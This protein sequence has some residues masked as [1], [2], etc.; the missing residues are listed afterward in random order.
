VPLGVVT[1]AFDPVLKFGDTASVRLETIGL[2][3]VLALGL[4]LAAR[5]ASVTPPDVTAGEVPNLRLDD[6][7]FIA[8]GTVPGAIAGGRLGYVLDHLDFY[9]ANP[10]L[11]VDATQGGMTLTWAVPLG[12][13]T[14]ALIARLVGAPVGRW[15]HAVTLPL[16]FVLGLG[17]LVGVLGGTGLGRYDT[18][19][20]ALMYEGPGPWG[21]LAA[22]VPSH[23]AQVYEAIAILCVMLGVMAIDR[24][25]LLGRRNGSL[26]FVALGL[27]AGARFVIAHTWR[28]PVVVS[29]LLRVEQVQLAGVWLVAVVGFLLRVRSGRRG[30]LVAV[31]T[32]PEPA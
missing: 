32:A 18:G 6:L 24:T 10:S 20:Y 27:W 17:K 31:E 12:I 14:G 16:L 9:Q 3:A 1:V 7:V 29:G 26:L 21:S 30:R 11:I 28:D 19:T 5:I 25:G 8:I 23:P 22:D 2:A 13:L 15:L 4:L